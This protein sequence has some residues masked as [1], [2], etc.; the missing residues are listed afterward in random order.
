MLLSG[1]ALT[2]LSIVKGI[3]SNA[4]SGSALSD[5]PAFRALSCS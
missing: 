3:K 4:T 2:T 1:D 5:D